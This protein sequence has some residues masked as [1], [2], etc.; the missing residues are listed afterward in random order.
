VEEGPDRHAEA[1]ERTRHL[2]TDPA[3]PAISEAAFAFD[4]VLIRADILERLP[5]GRWRLAEVKST[6][7]VK[8]EHLHDLAIQAY[9][10]TGSGFPV[11]EMQ[12]VH[13]DTSY[14]RGENEIDWHA[15][16]EREDVTAEVR[17][18]LPSVPE[19][20]AEMHVILSLPTAPEIR[21]S[22][23][24]FSP[25]PCEFWDRCTAD[26]PADWIINLPRLKAAMFA[27][28][29]GSGIESMR[30]I[31]PD[32]P[33][34]PG[35]QRVVNAVVS[36]REFI[37]DELRDAITALAPPT[38][39]LDFETFSPAIPLYAGTRPYQRIPFQWSMHHDDGAGEVCHFEFLADGGADP[40]RVF[41][42]TL[43]E[44]ISRTTGPIAVYSPFEATVLRA[45]AAFFPDLS[46]SLF[47]AIDRMVDLLPII[48]SHVTHPEFLGSNS[49][50]VV[51]PALVPGFSY[52][53]L[54]GVADGNDA[55][56]V[57]YRLATD[58]SL[59]DEDRGRYRRALLAYCGRD[60]LA[61]MDVHCILRSYPC[62]ASA[63]EGEQGLL[64]NPSVA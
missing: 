10:I 61:L 60:T 30:D 63:G 16:F 15:Y 64:S 29:D 38:S 31:P 40:R 44:A 57:F 1:V 20:V 36:G 45:L 25:Y 2:I 58:R 11:E 54:N 18:L 56:A 14:V 33:L 26:K 39:Y 12:L 42:E 28:L 41:A 6:T 46:G 24:C 22:G 47:V 48:K 62:S 13:V 17:G 32:F 49:I 27:E 19:R 53:D 23:H 4:R 8:P 5:S 35:Q 52:D 3:V 7:R 37:S 21:P 51:A 50:K 34:T 9:V 43:I 55:S 59:S